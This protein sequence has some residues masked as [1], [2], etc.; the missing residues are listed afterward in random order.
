M[1]PTQKNKKS[2]AHANIP[3]EGPL[4]LSLAQVNLVFLRVR[5]GSA[6]RRL[7]GLVEEERLANVFDLG[8]RAFQIK[9]LG[10]D[11]LENLRSC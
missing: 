1:H 10:E 6:V 4:S 3:V 7:D 9:G 11:Y 5:P 2:F 8:D